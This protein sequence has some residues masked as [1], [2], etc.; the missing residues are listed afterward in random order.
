MID[1]AVSALTQIFA[2][3]YFGYLLIG[4]FIGVFIGF[5]PG[6]GGYFA[7]SLMIPFVVRMDPLGAVV[8]ILSMHSV[9]T[10]GGSVSACLFGVPGSGQNIATVFD[11]YPMTQKGRGAEAV[12]A[13]LTASALGGVVGAFVLLLLI[14]VVRPLV[15]AFGS[16]EFLMMVMV[17]IAC[18]VTLASESWIKGFIMAGIGF[19]LSFVGQ[20]PVTGTVRFAFGTLY[21]WEGIPLSPLTMGKV[22]L[23]MMVV[24]AVKGGTVA[25]ARG[26]QSGELDYKQLFEGARSIFTHFW[27]FLRSTIIGVVVGIIPGLGGEAAALIAYAQGKQSCKRGH[28][29]GTGVVEGVVAPEAA[30]NAKEG[31]VLLPTVSFG[32]PGSG[33]MAILLGI[34]IMMGIQ[35][36]RKM[37]TEF[38]PLTLSMAWT[39]AVAN[40]VGVIVMMLLF[41]IFIK[42][43]KLK[44]ALIVPLIVTLIFVGSY[45]H[46]FE[47]G[48]LFVTMGAGALGYFAWRKQHYPI[49]PFLLG[50]VLGGLTERNYRITMATYGGSFIFR[51]ISFVLC[52]L[53]LLAVFYPVFVHFYKKKK[54]PSLSANKEGETSR[55]RNEALIVSSVTVFFS[56]AIVIMT[57][58]NVT[59]PIAR[60]FPLLISIPTLILCLIQLFSEIKDKREGSLVKKGQTSREIAMF[61]WFGFFAALIWL[62]NFVVAVPIFTYL[63]TKVYFKETQRLAITSAAI[64]TAAIYVIF[65]KILEMR[66][67]GEGLLISF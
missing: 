49:G 8:L 43:V 2:W 47:M 22:A 63:L 64:S 13:A 10:T 37:L 54:D 56:A 33:L 24:M 62:V 50:F 60:Q 29:F 6:I 3:P 31:G 5:V 26:D 20:D 41:K 48:D 34:L 55:S 45:S 61:L 4:T 53:F 25:P 21:L 35:P 7:L 40:V 52:I 11:G 17:G 51:P 16:G 44:V 28:L 46:F 67:L 1:V 30:N 14:P 36:G 58:M 59:N 42:S 9:I 32:V 27:L 65:F 12:G 38:L 18:V 66:A 39:V 15:L 19:L 57:L 23:A